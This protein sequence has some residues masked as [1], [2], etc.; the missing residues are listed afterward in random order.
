MTKSLFITVFQLLFLVTVIWAL[1]GKRE[2]KAP[3]Y[4]VAEAKDRIKDEYIVKLKDDLTQE[5]FSELQDHLNE[6]SKKKGI[7]ITLHRKLS[8]VIKG[9]TASLCPAAV[10]EL[11]WLEEVEYVEEDEEMEL[12]KLPVGLDRIDQENLPLDGKYQPP[13]GDGAGINVFVLD[14]GIL[15]D[16]RQ[17]K[18]RAKAFIDLVDDGLD[19]ND[20]H[21]HGTHVAGII[22][23]ET[24]GVAPGVTLHSARICD[25]RMK[26]ANGA[27]M[28]T[29]LDEIA[30]ADMPNTIV[31]IS[32]SGGK[33]VAVNEAVERLS[34][35]GFIVVVAAGNG[36]R[37]ACLNSPASSQSVITVGATTSEDVFASYSN[38]GSCVNILAPGSDIYSAHSSSPN[39]F[40][41]KSGTSMAC[42]HVSGVVAKLLQYD[43][44]LDLDEIKSILL[45]FAGKDLIDMSV[46]PEDFRADTP[47]VLLRVPSGRKTWRDDG[48]CGDGNHDQ[49]GNPATCDGYSN[50]PCCTADHTCGNDCTC[51][52]CVDYRPDICYE[53]CPWFDDGYCDDDYYCD[54]GTDCTDCG[55]RPPQ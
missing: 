39:A 10:K 43:N 37:D 32:I 19:G 53:S 26:G 23:G 27:R 28:I 17:F 13:L 47:N 6:L 18:G 30:A 38:Y 31:S 11:R 36:E 5:E 21:G 25:C 33:V 1:R 45:D 2:V 48:L 52:N 20:C 35:K 4:H 34:E 12:A 55:P 7:D 16:H 15:L 49:Y 42:P 44:T 8:T 54:Y 14:T 24:V 29:A 51:A 41:T 46:I 22:G 40:T 50:T 9:F 3:V